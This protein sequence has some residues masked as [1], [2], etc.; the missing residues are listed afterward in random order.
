MATVVPAVAVVTMAAV[1]VAPTAATAVAAAVTMAA[2]PERK[3]LVLRRVAKMCCW[4]APVTPTRCQRW[5]R[6]AT[7]AAAPCS[8]TP[9]WA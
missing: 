6:Q 9:C 7:R 5:L 8:L 3:G 1:T 4:L 2:A